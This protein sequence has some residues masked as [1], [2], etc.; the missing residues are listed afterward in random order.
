M[1]RWYG[2]RA[3]A[4]SSAPPAATRLRLTSGMPKPR[5]PGRDDQIARQRDLEAAGDGE[6]LDR[7]DQRL[8]RGALG[9]AAKP[10][11]AA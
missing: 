5:A 4:A 6:A 2:I 7:G 10:R 3:E 9:D 11:S 8:L 1:A